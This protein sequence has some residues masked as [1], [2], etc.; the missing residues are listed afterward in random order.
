[1]SEWMF[2][3][4]LF[5]QFYLL[6]PT[7]CPPI[8][9]ARRNPAPLKL[10]ID[11]DN[12]YVII[13]VLASNRCR[14]IPL[15]ADWTCRIHIHFAPDQK[16]LLTIIFRAFVTQMVPA[17]GVKLGYPRLHRLRDIQ[18]EVV[19]GGILTPLSLQ[20]NSVSKNTAT[21]FYAAVVSSN[22][23]PTESSQ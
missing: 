17:K 22:V 3:F 11:A 13:G 9:E 14:N 15:F 12:L 2:F 10:K 19:R 5:G 21:S 16:W 4:Y 8:G 23:Q 20:I 6:I 1:M 18:L 7:R